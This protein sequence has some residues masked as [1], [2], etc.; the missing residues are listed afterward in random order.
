[1]AGSEWSDYMISLANSMKLGYSQDW[2]WSGYLSEVSSRNSLWIFYILG[3][4]FQSD[5]CLVFGIHNYRSSLFCSELSGFSLPLV[6]WLIL[7]ATLSKQYS[8]NSIA[9]LCYQSV[10]FGIVRRLIQP[11]V[12]RMSIFRL[13]FSQ[14][15]S[16]TYSDSY[17]NWYNFAL[18][19]LCSIYPLSKLRGRNFL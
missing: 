15:E 6:F 8:G 14:L 1:M 5:R 9:K 10:L 17:L 2:S 16:P 19:P 18:V 7:R 3:Y 11:E 13:L 12:Q 4:I